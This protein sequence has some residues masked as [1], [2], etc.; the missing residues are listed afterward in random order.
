MSEA[1]YS[2]IEPWTDFDGGATV[3]ETCHTPVTNEPARYVFV[4]VRPGEHLGDLTR[5][6]Y[7]TNN[8]IN[9]MKIEM[10]NG[11]NIVGTIRC[12]K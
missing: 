11:G 3:D 7:G 6:V 4:D 12:P 1:F 2:S 5:R 9:R 10:A 8:V